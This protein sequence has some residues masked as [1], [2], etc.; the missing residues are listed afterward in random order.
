FRG[1]KGKAALYTQV[2]NVALGPSS[3][4][5]MDT[6]AHTIREFSCMQCASYLGWMIVRAHEAPE[7]WK[8]GH[9][10]LELALL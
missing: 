9:Y 7:R 4:L 5:L 1:Y 3:I 10:L 8:E 2:S 6:G